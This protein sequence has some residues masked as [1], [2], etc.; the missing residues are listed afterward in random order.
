MRNSLITFFLVLLLAFSTACKGTGQSGTNPNDPNASNGTTNPTTSASPV[1]PQQG[2]NQP[3]ASPP[4]NPT[5]P[6]NAPAD[7]MASN[8]SMMDMD[9]HSS[10]LEANKATLEPLLADNYQRTRIDGTVVN[11]AQELASLKKVDDMLSMEAQ[12][13]QIQGDTATVSTK[14]TLTSRDMSG[15]K[16]G[17]W[18][19]TDTF[20]K[21]GDRW[22]V[23]SSVEKK[24][25]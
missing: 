2:M 22:V 14:I 17:S 12:P 10:L 7:P 11:K 5:N 6:G 21:Q 9:F 23:V 18:R 4:S 19:T 24:D 25:Q 16:K 1:G 20:K 15:K 8:L 3:G 13:A